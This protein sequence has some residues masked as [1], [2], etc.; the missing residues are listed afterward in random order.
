MVSAI[1]VFPRDLNTEASVRCHLLKHSGRG[2]PTLE[3]DGASAYRRHPTQ[4]KEDDDFDCPRSKTAF[5]T[6]L[7]IR[8]AIAPAFRPDSQGSRRDGTF[9]SGD[10]SDRSG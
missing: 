3:A 7:L 2:R 9:T 6:R 5:S 10:E 8:S 1:M 4:D